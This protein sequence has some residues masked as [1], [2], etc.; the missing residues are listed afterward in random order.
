MLNIFFSRIVVKLHSGKQEIL[1][2][3][4]NKQ[5]AFQ[6]YNMPMNTTYAFKIQLR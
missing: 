1:V 3:S 5:N 4:I 6:I 2:S